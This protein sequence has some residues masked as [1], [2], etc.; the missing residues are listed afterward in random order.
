MLNS[1]QRKG[2]KEKANASIKEIIG[3]IVLVFWYYV[4]FG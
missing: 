3:A 1:A 2:L 4:L